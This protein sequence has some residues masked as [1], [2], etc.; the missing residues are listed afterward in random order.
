MLDRMPALLAA[1]LADVTPPANAPSDLALAAAQALLRPVGAQLLPV[2]VA[3]FAEWCDARA[4]YFAG[5][6]DQALQCRQRGLHAAIWLLHVVGDWPIG[7]DDPSHLVALL[8]DLCITPPARALSPFRDWLDGMPYVSSDP[9]QAVPGARISDPVQRTYIGR[10]AFPPSQ[11][12]RDALSA[13][14]LAA[15]H[16]PTRCTPA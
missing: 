12:A 3:R 16:R 4:T 7:R 2:Y 1:L 15:T 8:D 11:D 6:R 9:L 10:T 13:L 14:V 5:R